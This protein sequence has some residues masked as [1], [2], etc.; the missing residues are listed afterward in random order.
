MKIRLIII[1]ISVCVSLLSCS[2]DTRQ[3]YR[4][5][6]LPDLDR[7]RRI[8]TGIAFL[9]DAL[10][11]SSRSANIYYKRAE[12]LTEQKNYTAAL[13]DLNEALDITPNNG[14]YLFARAKIQRQLKRFDE[15]LSDARRAEVLG[16]DTPQL[17]TILGD[18][19]QQKRQ[20]RDARLYLNKTLQMA[21]Y[22]GEAYFYSGT[23]AAKQGDTTSAIALIQQS[24]ELKPRFLENYVELTN[25]YTRLKVRDEALRYN[26]IGLRYFPK[27]A[28]LH[29]TR[30][31]LYHTDKHL[32]SALVCYKKAMLYDT[33]NYLANFQAGLIYLKWGNN[34]L[35]VKNFEK[36]V[37][38]NSKFSSI[39]LLL[40][41]AFERIGNLD[42]AIE[43]FI[44]AVE[45][46]P[47][48]WKV[49]SKLYAAQRRNGYY[50]QYGYYPSYSNDS[51]AKS[52]AQSSA[53]KAD[54]GRV[55]ID[56]GEIKIKADTSKELRIKN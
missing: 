29:Y 2:T 15:A 54:S 24:I 49:K 53:P 9:T 25:I 14:N 18:L 44:L 51:S 20:F 23:L 36:V 33:T 34:Q 4:I 3:N 7:K 28:Q 17:Y 30:G 21:P 37:R 50:K 27:E 52:T 32:D 5:P 45:R 11:K 22:Q 39:H 56:I 10:K 31:F 48:D 6:P 16:E 42:K 47:S 19:T 40:G 43:Q 35:A 38:Q 26:N 12:L 55:I 46:N 8:E 13:T 41:M 1:G